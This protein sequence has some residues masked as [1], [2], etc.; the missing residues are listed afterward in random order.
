[1][2]YLLAAAGIG[3]VLIPALLAWALLEFAERCELK[4]PPRAEDT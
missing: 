2:T 1:V 4:I 3:C